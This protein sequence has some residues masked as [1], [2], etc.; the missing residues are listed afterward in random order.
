MTW[1]GESIENPLFV[2][3]Y[4]DAIRYTENNQLDDIN[5]AIEVFGQTYEN[6]LKEL[7]QNP[8]VA[9]FAKPIAIPV[10]NPPSYMTLDEYSYSVWYNY[11]GGKEY[12]EFGKI[13]EED[14]YKRTSGNRDVY[15]FNVIQYYSGVSFDQFINAESIERP[16]TYYV[17]SSPILKQYAIEQIVT[18]SNT[19]RQNAQGQNY[20]IIY[21]I[22]YDPSKPDEVTVETDFVWSP[23]M[24]QQ[25]IKFEF[26]F[27]NQQTTEA[28]LIGAEGL[29][30]ATQP[31]K[32]IAN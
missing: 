3:S 24:T 26:T 1:Q 13:K 23:G 32:L 11:G 20:P 2:A 12:L 14:L 9:S 15:Y 30:I 6:Y 17:I 8:N 25:D 4:D 31:I 19:I 7:T 29:Q 5:S 10:E 16:G 18:G 21:N 28:E 27:S 22:I